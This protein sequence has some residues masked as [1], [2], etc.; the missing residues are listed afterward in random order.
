M[1]LLLA[2]LAFSMATV[3]AQ[4]GTATRNVSSASDSVS[5]VGNWRS[6][7]EIGVYEAYSN[8]SVASC[9]ISFEGV[10]LQYVLHSESLNSL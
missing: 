7:N 5:Y 1:R 9:E 8:E 4:I 3:H 6:D 2:F 10:G